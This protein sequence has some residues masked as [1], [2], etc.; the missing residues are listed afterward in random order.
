MKQLVYSL[1]IVILIIAVGILTIEMLKRES[2]S[3]HN[4]FTEIEN[5]IYFDEW[6][7]AKHI[8]KETQNQWDKYKKIWPM[9]IDHLEIDNVTVRLSELQAYIL[10]Q[11]KTESLSK[12]AALKVLIKHI[13]EKE[14]FIIQNIL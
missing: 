4:L 6:E 2:E 3:L 7:K 11:D 5:S 12:L 1:I 14:S 8:V 10:N 9:L 13:P